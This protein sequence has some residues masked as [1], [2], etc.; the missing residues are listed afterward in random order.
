MAFRVRV[1][2]LRLAV[3]VQADLAAA[4]RRDQLLR[5]VLAIAFELQSA[6]FDVTF[7]GCSIA[8]VPATGLAPGGLKRTLGRRRTRLGRRVRRFVVERVA[9]SPRR[10]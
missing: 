7:Y 5:R 2:R 10:Q 6:Y 3:V 8:V 1:G 9:V 4:V